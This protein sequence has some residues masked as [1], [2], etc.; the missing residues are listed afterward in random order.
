M[1]YKELMSS[2]NKGAGTYISKK[3]YCMNGNKDLEES[4]R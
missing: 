4:L 2:M 3:G 1:N